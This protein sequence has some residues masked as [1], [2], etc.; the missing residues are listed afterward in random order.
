MK[1][2]QLHRGRLIR[3][4]RRDEQTSSNATPHYAA[5]MTLQLPPDIR[6]ITEDDIYRT[7]SQYRLWSFSPESLTGLRRKTH[8][9]ARERIEKQRK[10]AANG[11]NGDA[12][13]DYLSEEECLKLVQKYCDNLIITATKV[14][15]WPAAAQACSTCPISSRR[16]G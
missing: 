1:L 7:S 3:Q 11:A 13:V 6:Y 15:K 16:A 12:K 9:I 10:A 4:T 5:D 8:E 2:L 14:L